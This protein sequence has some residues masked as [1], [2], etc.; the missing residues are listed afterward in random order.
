MINYRKQLRKSRIKP[1]NPFHHAALMTPTQTAPRSIASLIGAVTVGAVLLVAPVMGQAQATEGIATPLRLRIV[2]GL[3]GGVQFPKHEMPFWQKTFPALTHGRATAD[4]VAFD[5]SGIRSHEMLRLIQ[6]GIVPFGT[7]LMPSV[8]AVDP[9][10]T[11][12]DLAGLNPDMASLKRSVAAYRPHV[13][14]T[15]RERYGIELLAIYAYPAQV[16]FCNKPFAGLNDLTGRKVRVSSPMQADLL[17]PL[18]AVPVLSEL[19]E[20]TAKV[21]NGNVDCAITAASTGKVVGLTDVTSHISGTAITWGVSFFAANQSAWQALPGQVKSL[22][23]Q[24]LPKLEQAIWADAEVMTTDALQ[25]AI[26]ASTCVA[27]RRAALTWVPNSDSDKRQL[28]DILLS[29][30]LPAWIARCG[31]HCVT[32]WN[33]RLAASTGITASATPG[34]LSPP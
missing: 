27:E 20:T 12:M 21:R 4:I 31:E 23:K 15:L 1:Q 13:E 30:V 24:E 19:S 18:G 25:C 26:G 28:R 2:G 29:H 5:K 33:K 6:L 7:A 11:A 14:Q 3:A 9:E 8:L 22:L 17:R 34:K 10:L 16:V 32:V